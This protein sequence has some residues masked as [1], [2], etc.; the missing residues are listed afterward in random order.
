V[1]VASPPSWPAPRSPAHVATVSNPYDCVPSPKLSQP[2]SSWADNAL[3]TPLL[4]GNDGE[5]P[6]RRQFLREGVWTGLFI[7]AS[8]S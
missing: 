7:G 6:A 2:F 4:G 1:A 8:G 5:R 3:Y